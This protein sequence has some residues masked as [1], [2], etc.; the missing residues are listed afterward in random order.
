MIDSETGEILSQDELWAAQ[1]ARLDGFAL[2]HNAIQL[3][4]ADGVA[5][6]PVRRRTVV[7]RRVVHYVRYLAPHHLSFAVPFVVLSW[8]FGLMPTAVI[9]LATYWSVR[10]AQS[11]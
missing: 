10:R 9:S 1:N 3:L 4:H 7:R 11:R 5:A 6:F 2:T 8:C